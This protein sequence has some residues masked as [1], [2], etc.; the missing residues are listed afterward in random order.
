MVAASLLAVVL[1]APPTSAP[2]T[3]APPPDAAPQQPNSQQADPAEGAAD[4][5]PKWRSLFD[6]KTLTGWDVTAFGGEGEVAVEDGAI[7]LPFGNNLT[8]VTVTKEVAKTLPTADYVLE[9]EAKR[10]SGTDFFCGLTVPMWSPAEKKPSHASL[11]LGGW[12]G[13]LVGLS[14]IDRF[15]ASEN[16]TTT[17]HAFENDQWYRVRLEV[18]KAGVR[19]LLDGEQLFAADIR[20]R[21]VST[22]SEVNLSK[23]LG[24]S[25]YVTTGAIR[26]VRIRPLT[27]AEVKAVNKACEPFDATGGEPPVN[28]FGEK[29]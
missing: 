11:I 12:G 26:G 4:G 20:D 23:P 15:D 1:L 16:E 29:N 27:E 19:A 21:I 18:T 6:G 8:G 25:T 7:L 13:G 24:V 9:L 10:V 28:E 14:S 5:K 17:Y 22:R 2:P 3:A